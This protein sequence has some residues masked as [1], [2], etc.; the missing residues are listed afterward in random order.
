MHVSAKV[1][2]SDGDNDGAAAAITTGVSHSSELRNPLIEARKG[3]MEESCG[4]KRI[5]EGNVNE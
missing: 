3:E 2:K 1:Q 5:A 4:R